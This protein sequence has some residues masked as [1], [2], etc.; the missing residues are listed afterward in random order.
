VLELQQRACEYLR[1]SALG[2]DV[3]ETV[4]DQMPQ[5]SEDKASLLLSRMHKNEAQTTDRVWQLAPKQS[6][7]D[8]T[9]VSTGPVFTPPTKPKVVSSHVS[10]CLSVCGLQ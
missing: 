2:A 5:Y 6:D 3:M 9:P 1:L 10:I 4:L 8:S 7:D